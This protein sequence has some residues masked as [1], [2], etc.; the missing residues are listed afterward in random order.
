MIATATDV[1]PIS[2][3]KGCLRRLG[4]GNGYMGA[5]SPCGQALV[6][7]AMVLPL[8]VLIGL[9]II[10]LSLILHDQ[11]VV[12]RMSREG[13]NL[14]SR[15]VP[16]YNAGEAMRSMA[17][18][19]VNFN[20]ANS[21][22]IFSVI[23]RLAAPNQPNNN[24]VI[25]YQR[26]EIGSLTGVSSVLTTA[27]GIGNL[28]Q[29]DFYTPNPS[30]NTNLRITNMPSNLDLSSGQFVY[31]TE[32]YSKHPTISAINGW[33]LNLPSTLYSVAYF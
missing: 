1:D 17:N 3:A 4:P 16:L 10:E 20:T 30:T 23:T 14:I 31:V 2:A 11:H 27:G 33:G 32:I 24:R 29:P 5:G 19:P 13:S 18:P 12:V 15:T 26:Y 8:L 6:E 28:V 9:G 25:L 7:F 22:L 21:K